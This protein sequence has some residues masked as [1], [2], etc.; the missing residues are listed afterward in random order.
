MSRGGRWR[1]DGRMLARVRLNVIAGT[2]FWTLVVVIIG[3]IDLSTGPDYAFGNFYLLAV[4]P[5]AWLLGREPGIA[6]AFASGLA[7]LLVDLAE[8]RATTLGPIIWNGTSRVVV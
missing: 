7:W 5:A 6:I 4:L 2:A 1:Q 8:R 3:V